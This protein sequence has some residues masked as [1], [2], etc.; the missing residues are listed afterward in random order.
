MDISLSNFNTQHG[1]QLHLVLIQNHP[2]TLCR[3]PPKEK[4]PKNQSASSHSEAVEEEELSHKFF[5]HKWV[6][7]MTKVQE[8]LIQ[9]TKMNTKTWDRISK[10]Q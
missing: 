6:A 7:M 9:M 4:N 1:S 8:S 5:A 2:L 3:R 10:V